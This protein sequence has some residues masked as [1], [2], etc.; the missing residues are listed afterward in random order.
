[1]TIYNTILKPIILYGCEDWSLTIKTEFKI[2][3]AEMRVLLL[4]EGVTR[5]NRI[6]N[7]SIAEKLFVFPPTVVDGSQ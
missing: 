3:A 4:T 7:T 6:V 5:R 1:M 2:Q